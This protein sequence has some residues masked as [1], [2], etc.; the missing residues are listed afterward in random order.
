MASRIWESSPHCTVG[1]VSRELVSCS[2]AEAL[3]SLAESVANRRLAPHEL[4]RDQ[5]HTF[6]RIQIQTAAGQ[7]SNVAMHYRA[8][9]MRGNGGVVSELAPGPL[10]PIPRGRTSYFSTINA[11]IDQ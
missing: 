11:L 7:V 8:S 3:Q 9:D 6:V 5:L 4:L 2:E 10:G 1:R